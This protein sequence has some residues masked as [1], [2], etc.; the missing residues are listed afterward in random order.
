MAQSTGLPIAD[1]HSEGR[2]TETGMKTRT[3]LV[4]GATRGTGRQVM[5]QALAA[6]YAVTA[7]ARDPA[8]ID[9][10]HDV[11]DQRLSVVRGDVLDPATLAPA[12]AGQDA[13]I[14]S[15][16]VTSRGPTTL[17][18]EGM[19]HVIQAMHAAGVKRLVAVSAWPLSSDDGDTLPARLLLK[20]LIWA[21]LRPVYADMARME[22]EIRTSGL[23]W[24]IVRP[25]RLTD[26]PA[27]GRYRMALNRSVRRGYIIARTDLASAILTLLE[28]PTAIRTAIG[29]GY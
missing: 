8:R 6:G 13:V 23:D 20:P 9:V 3:L 27:T 5:Q 28:D 12:M 16:G 10:P 25:P 21:L 2:S 11:P 14:S 29:I 7:L 26:K 19:R 4:I 17:Y 1:A 22:D 15:I 24:T 18:S